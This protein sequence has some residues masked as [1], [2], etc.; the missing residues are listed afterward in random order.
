MKLWSRWLVLGTLAGV[1]LA[2]GMAPARAGL[3]AQLNGT[4]TQQLDGRF[5]YDYVLSVDA[6]SS[7]PGSALEIDIPALAAPTS[8]TGPNG[9]IIE[10]APTLGVLSWTSPDSIFDISPG[11]SAAFSFLSALAPGLTTFRLTGISFSGLEEG[12]IEQSTIGPAVP[13]PSGLVLAGTAAAALAI[14][15]SWRNR[16]IRACALRTGNGL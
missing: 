11:S 15:A 14:S 4:A 7:F 13:E 10:F 2:P 9:W 6:A 5:E 8:I 3:I 12:V 16:R 1:L